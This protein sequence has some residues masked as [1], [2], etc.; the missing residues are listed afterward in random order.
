AHFFRMILANDHRPRTMHAEAER[1][2][3]DLLPPVVGALLDRHDRRR[4]HRLSGWRQHHAQARARDAAYQ[5]LRDATY[6][7]RRHGRERDRG[8]GLEL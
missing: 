2:D 3:R 4:A 5:R 6:R 1:T 8:D 7:S